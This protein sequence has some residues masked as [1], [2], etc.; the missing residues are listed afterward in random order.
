MPTIRVD[1]RQDHITKGKLQ[2]GSRCPLALALQEA[3]QDPRM[4]VFCHMATRDRLT[5]Y[6]LPKKA[7]DFYHSFDRG[8][9]VS[10]F[11]FD[12]DLTNINEDW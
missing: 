5:R 2:N 10:P 7:C 9:R 3:L 4:Q 1:V 11:S 12:L 6:R 8:D